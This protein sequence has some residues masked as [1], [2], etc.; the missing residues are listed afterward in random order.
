MIYNKIKFYR[1]Q[2]ELSQQAL[3]NRIGKDKSTISRYEKNEIQPPDSIKVR[4]AKELKADVMDIFFQKNV[5]FN[6]I[7]NKTIA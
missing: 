3:G 2:A 6:S 5:E 7:K 1:E 4:I